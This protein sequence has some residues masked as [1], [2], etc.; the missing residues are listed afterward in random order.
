MTDC[1]VQFLNKNKKCIRSP[2]VHLHEKEAPLCSEILNCQ[3][4]SPLTPVHVKT[5]APAQRSLDARGDK[6]R[7]PRRGRIHLWGRS[8]VRG[9]G[10]VLQ[11]SDDKPEHSEVA[12]PGE[13]AFIRPL[14]GKDVASTHTSCSHP[15][16]CPSRAQG[17]LSEEV[18]AYLPPF[19]STGG[20]NSSSN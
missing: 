20:F 11:T 5:C 15:G 14:L 1:G 8:R 2:N 4:L 9:R 3:V 10:G 17:F 19:V 6:F 13:G 12:S 7:S 16:H 18:S